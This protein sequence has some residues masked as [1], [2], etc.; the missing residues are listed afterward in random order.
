MQIPMKFPCAFNLTLIAPM[1]LAAFVPL[2]ANA[3][4]AQVGIGMST[5]ATT[6]LDDATASGQ[7]W[8]DG[9]PLQT[10][11]DAAALPAKDWATVALEVDG[12]MRSTSAEA[13][14]QAQARL[15]GSG[16]VFSGNGRVASNV[17][18]GTLMLQWHSSL[19]Q[20]AGPSREGFAR[21]HP[22]AELWETFEVIYP[23]ER[24]APVEVMLSLRLSGLLDG[25]DGRVTDLAGVEAYLY[26]S[27]V[28][29][30]ESHLRLDP[31]WRA[32]TSVADSVIRYAGPLQSNGCNVT[33]GLCSGLVGVYAALDLRGRTPGAAAD[34]WQTA[35]APLDLTFAGQL[36]LQVSDGVTLVRGDVLDVLPAVAWAQVSSVPEPSTA[37]SLLAGL[38][39]LWRGRATYQPRC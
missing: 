25:N 17:D 8:R 23:I 32:E 11:S 21:G 26:L 7:S 38:L 16:Q 31:V 35:R 19:A 14:V 13:E 36:A 28:D 22:Y 15:R 37:A 3:G 9:A 27:G 29:T 5:W 6:D 10:V 18:A 2:T 30:G 34:A 20:D 1:L 24:V 4:R 39:L 33:S 12:V